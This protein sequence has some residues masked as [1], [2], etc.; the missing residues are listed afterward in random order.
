MPAVKGVELGGNNFWENIEQMAVNGGGAKADANLWR[1]NFWSDYEGL[2]VN[3][4][5]VGDTSYHSEKF[6]ENMT[7]R[8]PILRALLYSP[9]AQAIEFAASSFPLVKPL[10]KFSDPAPRIV[11][12]PLPADVQSSTGMTP[13][14]FL[15]ALALLLPAGSALLLV[16]GGK[17][18][19]FQDNQR[20]APRSVPAAAPART[21]EQTW[22]RASKVNKSYGA[23]AVLKDVSFKVKSGSALA[24]WG[25]NGAG[26]TTLVKA[27]LGLVPF[28]GSIELADVPVRRNGK[29]VRGLVGYVP[30]EVMFYDWSVKA[31]LDFYARLKRV[32]PE[33][34][35]V[36]LGQLG[37]EAHAAKPVPALSG[38]LKQR[39]ALALAL[40]SDPPLLLLDEPTANLDTQARAEYVKLIAQLKHE[41]KT[42]VFASHRLEEVEALADGVLWLAD[43]RAARTMTLEE[44]RAQVAP[45]V[46]LTLWLA[47]GQRERANEFL[48]D[49]GWRAHLNGHGTV[50]VRARAEEKIKALQMLHE[51]GF[52]VDNFEIERHT[53]VE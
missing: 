50:I 17:F 47:Q 30:Q 11:P 33:R 7:D 3:G 20:Q 22:L 26:K 44:W 14:M 37:L 9:S 5:G 51:N 31:T 52:I 12:P 53:E 41:G 38:G 15:A 35:P 48:N 29:R 6:F 13:G 45:A 34:V 42:I 8:E 21:T 16:Y 49:S 1:G 36:L 25:P 2:D 32:A 46:E 19:Q 28:E 24:L 43:D 10:P 27:I 40:L 4:D 23:S 39:L 18:M